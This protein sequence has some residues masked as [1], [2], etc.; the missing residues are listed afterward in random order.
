MEPIRVVYIGVR[1]AEHG[2]RNG[3]V[4]YL[5]AIGALEFGQDERV[6]LHLAE[7]LSDADLLRFA[8]V[9]GIVDLD[10]GD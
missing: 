4:F 9:I 7:D 2:D 10:R 6:P 3:Q 8:N 5:V 1:L